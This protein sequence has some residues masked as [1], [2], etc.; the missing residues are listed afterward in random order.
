L[1]GSLKIGSSL[2]VKRTALRDATAEA[3]LARFGD[4]KNCPEEALAPYEEFSEVLGGRE[5]LLLHP[6]RFLY[7][8]DP[9]TEE[10]GGYLC[11]YL[12]DEAWHYR[13]ADSLS[14]P[15]ASFLLS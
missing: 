3:I 8:R 13:T 1:Q 6:R 2:L 7:R 9:G 5:D 14:R 12:T 4:P 15:L 11:G 10:V